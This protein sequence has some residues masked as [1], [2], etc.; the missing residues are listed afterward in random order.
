MEIVKVEGIVIK[1]IAYGETSKI[2]TLLTK[3][4]GLVSVIS[5]GCRGMKSKLRGVSG[6]LTYGNFYLVYKKNG[7]STLTAVDVLN[8]FL[9]IMMDIEKISYASYLLE[10][11]E[12]VC[13]E[14][15]AEEV[16]NLLKTGL[17]KINDGLA[18]NVITN[19][20]EL[21]Y[22]DFL[23]VAPVVDGCVFCGSK[24]NIQTVSIEH[25]GYLCCS[26][27][28]G[29]KLYSE[30][31]LKFLRMFSLV[32]LQKV[33]KIDVKEDVQK[34]INQFLDEYYDRYTGLYLHSKKFLKNLKKVG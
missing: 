18:P 33:S 17:E 27:Y 24:K 14:V 21:Q 32:D 34:E 31:F 6:K 15:V 30:R 26:C 7:L 10:L 23:G 11:T 1:D 12:Q 9:N 3:D 2:L 19:I 20:L 5:K 8:P 13:K 4:Y 29:E 16:F 28:R 22:L 25:G